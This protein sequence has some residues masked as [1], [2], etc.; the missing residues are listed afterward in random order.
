MFTSFIRC[1]A[2]VAILLANAAAAHAHHSFN[3]DFNRADTLV[4]EGTVTEFWFA[5][6]HARIYLDV[7]RED[8]TVEEW[9]AEGNSRNNLIR[10]GWSEDTVQPGQFLRINGAR[11]RDGSNSIGWLPGTPLLGRD[12]EVVGPSRRSEAPA[13]AQAPPTFEVDPLWL[14]VPDGRVF[15]RLR[16]IALDENDHLWIAHYTG[17][18]A[19]NREGML[20]GAVQDPPLSEC[21]VPLPP[22][23]EFDAYGNFVQGWGGPSEDY[24]WPHGVHGLHVD[25]TGHVWIAGED[26]RDAMILKF[27]KS[28]DLVLQIG[29]AQPERVL[30]ARATLGWSYPAETTSRDTGNV[31]RAADLWVYPETNELFVADGYGNHRIVVFDA[32]TGEYLRHW[33]AYGD[34]PRDDVPGTPRNSRGTGEGATQFHVPHDVRISN[35]A[36][37]YVADRGNNRIQVF[38]L[39]GDFLREHFIAQ[40]TSSQSGTAYSLAF[41]RDPEQTW[42]YVGDTG[43]GRVRILN[44]RTFEEVGKFGQLGHYPGQFMVLHNIRTDSQGNLYTADLRDGVV[45]KWVN[46]Q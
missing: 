20:L 10:A 38:T 15:G 39:A 23:V 9:M 3:A 25:H 42:L 18:L 13:V 29:Q 30:E 34:E 37:V 4:L 24:D 19:A 6:P 46:V 2:S 32:E 22:I 7:E 35:D 14:K 11:A 5:N 33:G 21:C 43:N 45:Q 44:R 16:G 8:G 17:N 28:G 12:G 26:P 40:H 36:L 31:G 27:T 1:S 41:S